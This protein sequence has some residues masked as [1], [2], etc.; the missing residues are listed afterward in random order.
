MELKS[1][2]YV[3]FQINPIGK[4]MSHII[5]PAK[6]EILRLLNVY[7]DHPVHLLTYECW[8]TIKQEK[9]TCLLQVRVNLY[10]AVKILTW[11]LF[12]PEKKVSI[13]FCI[14]LF[15]Q[16]LSI[17]NEFR[18][19]KILKLAEYAALIEKFSTEPRRKMEFIFFGFLFIQVILI[20]L[21]NMQ[22]VI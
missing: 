21:W 18:E 20:D 12:T 5:S 22:N 14:C 11:I 2:Y 7:K 10:F 9:I 1:L 6:C 17:Y 15:S 13:L 8:Y 19:K 3:H 4:S 16:Q